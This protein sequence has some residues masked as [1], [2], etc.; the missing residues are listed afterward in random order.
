MRHAITVVILDKIL[1]FLA[2]LFL[3]VAGDIGA[4]REAARTLLASY[5][6]RT[7]RE[8]RHAALALAFSFGALDALSRSIA[9]ELTVNQVLRLRGNANALNRA[10]LL[11]EQALEAL[12]DQLPEVLSDAPSE[13]AEA[14][15]FDLPA[16]LEPADMA[17][18]A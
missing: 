17:K 9:S 8:L 15:A 10:A 18:F 16:S 12:R 13:L 3:D 1:A 6:P 5:D 11:N 14:D 4:A 7:N 2:P